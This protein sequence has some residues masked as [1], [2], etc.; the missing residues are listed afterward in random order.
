MWKTFMNIWAI[1]YLG[2]PQN[3]WV[4]QAKAFISTKFTT[5]DNLLGCNTVPIAVEAEWP[6]I[7]ERYH[8]Q[9][10]RL[11]K[12][13]ILD[14]PVAPIKL[15]VDYANPAMSHTFGAKGYTPDIMAFGAQHQLPTGNYEQKPKTS[16]NRM[17]LMTT[18]QSEYEAIVAGLRPKSAMNKDNPNEIVA[19]IIPG[20]EGL[21]YREKKGW[22]DPYNFL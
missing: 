6:L 14:H 19:D 11:V 21:A 12:K 22:D 7:A 5:L 2:V 1:P 8:E 16:I 15:I 9:L 20:D 17:N 10:R 3:L 4:A 13:L 18:A